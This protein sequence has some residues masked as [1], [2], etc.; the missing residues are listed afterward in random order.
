MRVSRAL[1]PFFTSQSS[2]VHEID[3]ADGLTQVKGGL[4][5]K[6]YE[7]IWDDE[8]IDKSPDFIR[9]R[10]KLEPVFHQN[11]SCGTY[12]YGDKTHHPCL[13]YDKNHPPL[14]AMNIVYD[15]QGS[16]ID[17]LSGKESLF[18][19]NRFLGFIL[20][21]E[22]LLFQKKF[23]VISH[24]INLRAKLENKGTVFSYDSVSQE[25]LCN[26]HAFYRPLW[27]YGGAFSPQM[28]LNHMVQYYCTLDNQREMTTCPLFSQR[29]LRDQGMNIEFLN[30]YQTPKT[31]KIMIVPPPKT[32]SEGNDSL[33]PFYTYTLEEEIVQ[34]H[35]LFSLKGGEGVTSSEDGVHCFQTRHYQSIRVQ[36][37][38]LSP[39]IDITFQR[40]TA[41]EVL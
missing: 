2:V 27:G 17:S 22:K 10:C 3:V 19:G 6:N 39:Y 16:W 29:Y 38:G 18:K 15:G 14:L 26:E 28:P 4:T 24:S 40:Y 12:I 23:L 34:K 25:M 13:L 8:G 37:L 21:I 1:R 31:G 5:T 11:S 36:Q 9:L 33:P 30:S 35:V 41:K 20:N 32:V 7:G